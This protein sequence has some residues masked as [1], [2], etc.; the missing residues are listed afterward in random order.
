MGIYDSRFAKHFD[1][2]DEI[3]FENRSVHALGINIVAKKMTEFPK[4]RCCLNCTKAG[5]QNHH[6]M[7]ISLHSNEHSLVSCNKRQLEDQLSD[8]MLRHFLVRP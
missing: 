4:P 7:T 8:G 1:F 6:I 5:V 2:D 3:W